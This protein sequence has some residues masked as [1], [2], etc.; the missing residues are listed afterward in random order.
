L[1]EIGLECKTAIER[2]KSI[3]ASHDSHRYN[4]T[5]TPVLQEKR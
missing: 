4:Y 2:A 5:E 1:K 3:R